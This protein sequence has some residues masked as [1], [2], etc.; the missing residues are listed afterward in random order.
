[1]TTKDTKEHKGKNWIRVRGQRQSLESQSS[2]R[3]AA[4]GTEKIASP[5]RTRRD[6]KERM[7]AVKGMRAEAGGAEKIA[8]Q[9]RTRRDNEEQLDL[10]TGSKEKSWIAKLAKKGR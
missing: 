4:K 2:L 1:F 3:T 8:K 5:Q 10:G 9:Q 7:S 6:T